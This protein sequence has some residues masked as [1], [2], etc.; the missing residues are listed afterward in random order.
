[1]RW[2]WLVL[3]SICM[4]SAAAA[5]ITFIP[6][7]PGSPFTA[8]IGAGGTPTTAAGVDFWSGGTPARPYQLLGFLMG[9]EAEI[10]K[11]VGTAGLAAQV[12][13]AGGDALLVSD[14]ADLPPQAQAAMSGIAGAPKFQFWI[15]KYLS[16]GAYAVAEDDHA[17]QLTEMKAWTEDQC[18]DPNSITSMAGLSAE[19]RKAVREEIRKAMARIAT[20]TSNLPEEVR[21]RDAEMHRLT[22]QM[23]DCQEQRQ[24]QS[25]TDAAIRGGLGTEVQ[26]TSATR[27]AVAGRSIAAAQDTLADG[28][29]CITVRDVIIIDGEETISQ[30]RMCR[31]AGASGYKKA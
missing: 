27:P 13:A 21:R 25:A 15:V 14:T 26:W 24:V 11:S 10:L 23:L 5:R 3:L 22:M 4:A 7:P 18:S 16:A 17:G 6:L 2:L 8:K 9:S 12:R 20:A 1:M 30:K 29:H 31:P 28:T 19:Q